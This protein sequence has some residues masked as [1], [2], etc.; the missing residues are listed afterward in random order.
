[1][2]VSYVSKKSC[3]ILCSLRHEPLLSPENLIGL[4]YTFRSLLHQKS[5]CMYDVR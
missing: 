1:M 2:I 4:P 5:I 3:P